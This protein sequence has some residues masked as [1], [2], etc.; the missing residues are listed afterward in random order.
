MKFPHI[1]FVKKLRENAKLPTQ[2][3]PDDV[4]W[5][6]Y[7]STIEDLGDKLKVGMGI[8]VEP[9]QNWYIEM[10]SRSS[11]SKK[12]LILSNSVG[13]IDPGYKGEIIAIFNKLP[14]FSGVEIGER[15]VQLIPR[16]LFT[17]QV[18]EIDELGT[19][20]RSIGGFG[21]SNKLE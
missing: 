4:G 13:I 15:L 16:Q 14:D 8:A 18:A 9:P 6:C 2:S 17:F 5:D 7:V 11:I 19:S 21:S 3:Y 20:I 1:L 12:G 10:F